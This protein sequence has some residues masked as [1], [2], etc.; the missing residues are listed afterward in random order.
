M[1]HGRLREAVE[2]SIKSGTKSGGIDL[3]RDAATIEMLRYMADTLD[4]KEGGPS[5]VRYISPN[6]FLTYCEKLGFMPKTTGTEREQAK[7]T[8][9]SIVGNSKWKKQA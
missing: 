3:E 6:A 2:K 1:A 9:L 5:M 8:V 7:A 4:D